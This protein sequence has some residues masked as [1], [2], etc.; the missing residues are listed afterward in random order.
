M[1]TAEK[2]ITIVSDY[3][4]IEKYLLEMSSRDMEI[5]KARHVA[6]Y[7][8]R[9]YTELTFRVIGSH[10]ERD[11]ATVDHAIKSVRDRID[12][13]KAYKHDFDEIEKLIRKE[14]EDQTCSRER[15]ESVIF[16]END[17]YK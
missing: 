17:W 2:I 4:N 1:I 13:E 12:T 8:C 14:I 15:S 10:F 11:H 9:Y 6:M 7:F 5:V 16:Q 3:F